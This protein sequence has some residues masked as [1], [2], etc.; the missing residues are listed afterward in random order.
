MINISILV[1]IFILSNL[2]LIYLY[3][4]Y[5]IFSNNK[6]V[7]YFDVILIMYIIYQYYIYYKFTSDSIKRISNF[8]SDIDNN[9]ITI[10]ISNN[11]DIDKTSTKII[12]WIVDTSNNKTYNNYSMNGVSDIINNKVII[13]LK[14]FESNSNLE[15]KY[16]ILSN[17][18][19]GEKFINDTVYSLKINK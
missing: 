18:E 15:L 8:T 11:I 2:Y 6:F 4:T 7:I 17:S 13:K 9:T 5:D 16:R 10:D 14:D 3:D 19:L 1:T 12:Y